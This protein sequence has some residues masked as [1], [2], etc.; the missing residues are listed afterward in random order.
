MAARC[1]LVCYIAVV[2]HLNILLT[3]R[4]LGQQQTYLRQAKTTITTA[5][6]CSNR[7]LSGHS[8]GF[9]CCLLGH[10]LIDSD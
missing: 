10:L 6:T 9:T 3:K 4:R 7:S 5:T 2:G 8:N 1:C